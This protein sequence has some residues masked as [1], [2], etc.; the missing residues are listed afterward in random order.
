MK[1]KILLVNPNSRNQHCFWDYP[2]VIGVKSRLSRGEIVCPCYPLSLAV[3]ASLIRKEKQAEVQIVDERVQD[4]DFNASDSLVGITC[5]TLQVTR[6]FEIARV[7]RKKNKVILGGPHF[8]R[9]V[10]VVVEEALTH[11]DSVVVGESDALWKAIITD[12][13]SGNLKR[14]YQAHEEANATVLEDLVLPAFDL[15][16]LDKYLYRTLETSRG[17]N[18][19]C[20]FCSVS[21]R[22]RF[23]PVENVIEELRYLRRIEHHQKVVHRSVFFADSLLNPD[24]NISQ[25][26]RTHELMESLASHRAE[27]YLGNQFRWS[28][29]VDY[30]IGRDK[31]LMDLMAKAGARRLVIGFESPYFSGKEDPN[32]EKLTSEERKKLFRETVARL[33]ARGIGVIGCFVVGLKGEPKEFF[34]EIC[35]FI[36]DTNIV[37]AQVF[38]VT[39]FPGT[40]LFEEFFKNGKLF[41]DDQ[42]TFIWDNYDCT[43]F[44]FDAKDSKGMMNKYR[45]LMKRIYDDNSVLER[46]GRRSPKLLEKLTF[47]DFFS[48]LL[49]VKNCQDF[50]RR[51]QE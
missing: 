43:R 31:K 50:V 41:T 15:L 3:I 30:R 51:L 11:A 7:F 26:R 10:S 29:Q 2:R 4:I 5:T 9:Y 48:E 1:R 46:M 17:C 8:N 22:L 28:G 20:P 33:H 45:E 37:L 40:A 32:E 35:D 49:I 23:K 25:R 12:F 19:K 39:P 38:I 47:D 18:R 42:N 14:V 27:K 36:K 34:Q 13:E 24:S 21:T 16:P 6:A 44:V